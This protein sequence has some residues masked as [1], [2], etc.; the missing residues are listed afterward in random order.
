MSGGII[1][2]YSSSLENLDKNGHGVKLEGTCMLV[3]PP[4][5]HDGY[6]LT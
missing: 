4:P 2:S 5:S 3:R 6:I 1:T